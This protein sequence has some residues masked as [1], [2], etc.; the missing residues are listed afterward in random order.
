MNAAQ[1]AMSFAAVAGLLT[2]TPGL[3]TALVLRTAA[4]EGRRQGI[5]AA[6]GICLGCLAWGAGVSA[7]IAL[8]A[9]ASHGVFGVLRLIGGAYTI[10]LGA[11]LIRAG[12]VGPQGP[13][14]AVEMARA[15][16]GGGAWLLRGLLTNILNPKVG[17]FYVAFLPVFTP[18]HVDDIAF[19]FLLTGIH[20]AESM[21]WFL[22]LIAVV[23]RAQ[24]LLSRRHVV[25]I[26]DV[27]TGCVLIG[28]GFG[29]SLEH[30]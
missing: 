20:V 28:F 5:W 17:A 30:G 12:I 18:A 9:A 22:C 4:V 19:G 24:K 3:D 6:I 8:L 27:L 21:I 1:S 7:G 29:L 10:W 26:L 25:R 13:F 2:V 11:G 15:G 16:R 23:R 14:A